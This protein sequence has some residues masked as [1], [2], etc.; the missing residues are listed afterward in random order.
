MGCETSTPKPAPRSGGESKAP[1][2]TPPATDHLMKGIFDKMGPPASP[3][4]SP[5]LTPERGQIGASLLGT[6]D[7][8]LM[9][10][11]S[12]DGSGSTSGGGSVQHLQYKLPSDVDTVT[13]VKP[14]VGRASSF[15]S[16]AMIDHFERFWPYYLA[17][18]IF[19]I[20]VSLMICYRKQFRAKWQ[21]M[22][23]KKKQSA[24]ESAQK[25]VPEVPQDAP[26]GL[27]IV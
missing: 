21:S 27:D 22:R 18:L 11:P 4:R 6:D 16:D 23:G 20:V 25:Q 10:E 14:E 5:P 15:F 7:E 19:V 13:H 12:A 1:G 3:E 17:F 9:S 24:S 2:T 26:I 8:G